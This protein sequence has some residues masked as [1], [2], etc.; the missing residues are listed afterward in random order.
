MCAKEAPA[1][2]L[3][4]TAIEASLKFEEYM[5]SIDFN[6]YLLPAEEK[7]EVKCTKRYKNYLSKIGEAKSTLHLMLKKANA[8]EIIKCL[9]EAKNARLEARKQTERDNEKH[10]YFAAISKLNNALIKIQLENF[11]EE[12]EGG[13]FSKNNWAK[14]LLYNELSICHSGLAEPSIS[15]GYAERSIAL[16]RKIFT[17]KDSAIKKADDKIKLLYTF[18]LYN[19]G[20]AERLL[21]DYDQ[22]LK[23]FGEILEIYEDNS[24]WSDGRLSDY[25][26]ALIRVGMILI[27]WGRGEEALENLGKTEKLATDDNRVQEVRLEK[28][29]AHIDMKDYEHKDVLPVLEKYKDE[30]FDFTFSKRKAA[31]IELRLV[32]EFIRNQYE[33]FYEQNDAIS[34][35]IKAKYVDFTKTAK[36]L[37]NECVDRRD[38]DSFKKVCLRLSDYFHELKKNSEDNDQRRKNWINE[39]RYYYLYLCYVIIFEEPEILEKAGKKREE[40]V[41]DWINENEVDKRDLEL[42]INNYETKLNFNFSRCIRKIDDEKYLTGFFRT[43]IA[44]DMQ[45]VSFNPKNKKEIISELKDTLVNLFDEKENFTEAQK[46]QEDFIT[47]D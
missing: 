10:Y 46:I 39:L 16:L 1:K 6:S 28:I 9:F 38:S 18:G 2:N 8:N 24:L 3:I 30:Q 11:K 32:T 35:T 37:L 36:T 13:F 5:D 25:Y 31:V 26:S 17:T 47:Y 40:I 45:K 14:V 27:D 12:S 19:K 34:K 23:T 43:Y 44:S 42:L 33:R 15:L 4:N 41:H 20:E 29:R 7:S 22:S 21:H